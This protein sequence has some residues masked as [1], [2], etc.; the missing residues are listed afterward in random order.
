MDTKRITNEV[1]AYFA[2]EQ[3]TMAQVAARLGVTPPAVTNQ[4][5]GRQFS[6]KMAHKYADEFGFNVEYLLTGKGTL[7]ADDSADTGDDHTVPL[8]PFSVRAGASLNDISEGMTDAQCERITSPVRGAEL[9]TEV[10][11]DSMAPAFPAGAR[12][13]LARVRDTIAW[14]EVYVLDTTDGQMLKRIMP[15]DS[16]DVWELRSDNPAYPPFRIRTRCVR[17][18]WRVLL[19]MIQ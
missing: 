14:G 3:M 18:V 5:D 17:G 19:R 7:L 15:T 4:L 9:A 11:G 16:E 2:Q 6:A 10:V 12:V 13:L 8:F 1:R